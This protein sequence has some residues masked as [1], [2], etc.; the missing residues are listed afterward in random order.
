MTRRPIQKRVLTFFAE[1][2]EGLDRVIRQNTRNQRV[3]R[4]E[5]RL[6]KLCTIASHE[7]KVTVLA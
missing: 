4:V 1:S 3:L 7:A 5:K 6:P 2:D